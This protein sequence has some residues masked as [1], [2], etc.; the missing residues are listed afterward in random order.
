M[1]LK[2]KLKIYKLKMKLAFIGKMGTGKDTCVDYLVDTYGGTKLSFSEPLYDILHYAQQKCGFKIEKD[3]KFLQLVGT[4]WAR[5]K[6]E[7]VWLKL[8]VEKSKTIKGNLYCSDVRFINELKFLKEDGWTCIKINRNKVNKN[9]VGSG[10]INHP[11][12]I[13]IDTMDPI[14]FDYIIDNNFSLEE[15]Y[16]KLIHIIKK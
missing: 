6:D 16:T 12:E 14:L 15:L 13:E 9:R 8:M 3:R 11:S 1:N 5:N 4:E 7:N 2:L 10:Y